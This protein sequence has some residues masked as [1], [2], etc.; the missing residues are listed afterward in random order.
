M[1]R[2]REESFLGLHFD[3]HADTDCT[4]V[5]KTVTDEMI[6][7]IVDKVNPEYIQCDCSGVPGYSSYPT[8]VANPVPGFVKDQLRIW[9]NVTQAADIP[10]LVHF[11]GLWS[12]KNVRNHPEW[13]CV[14]AGG[15]RSDQL[16]SYFSDYAEELFIPQLK[17]LIDE[18]D[19]NGVWVDADS[20]VA[21][22]DFR[23]EALDAYKSL[24]GHDK[25]D[26][27][28]DSA[29]FADFT[30]FCRDKYRSYLRNYVDK[31][32]AYSPGFQVCTNWAYSSYMPE[33]VDIDVDFLSGDVVPLNGFNH[34]RFDSRYLVHQGTPW[35][36]M[37]WSFAHKPGT[38][39][40]VKTAL[41]MMQE[42]AITIAQGGA[43]TF[44]F[45]QTRR[46]G[47]VAKWQM[48]IMAEVAQFCRA[49]QPYCFQ[50]P[51]V[52]QI[53][54][55]HSS[56][57]YY[58]KNERLFA[59]RNPFVI[60]A[61]DMCQPQIGV[62]QCLLEAQNVVDVVSEHQVERC[63]DAYGLVVIP[64]VS[65][66]KEDFRQ[67]LL[68]YV[69]QGGNLL[70]IGTDSVKIFQDELDV[71]LEGPFTDCR[72]LDN[73]GAMTTVNA[74]LKAG[75]SDDSRKIGRL[76]PVRDFSDDCLDAASVR[77]YGKGKIAG[78]YFDIGINYSF[79]QTPTLRKFLKK[80]VDTSFTD[81]LV[82]VSGS[83]FIDVSIAADDNRLCVNLLNTSGP[84]GN[85]HVHVFDELPVLRDIEVKVAVKSRPRNVLLQP[86]G[87][88]LEYEFDG[89]SIAFKL[90]E[91]NVHSVVV[92]ET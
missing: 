83:H 70:L 33:P 62:L 79:F 52:P 4:E 17:E 87:I 18:Y 81:P 48:D 38:H 77:D 46:D 36:I 78:I 53:A 73:E 82:R 3:F 61:E 92:I 28:T 12:Q 34:S 10:L 14:D 47:S 80:I 49:R 86:D 54:M 67:K 89:N 56:T 74:Y 90:E 44:Y 42:A 63:L 25:Q 24:S 75:I 84:H 69:R 30:E 40:D 88:E 72:W 43:V 64:E 32:H 45:S 51:Q 57:H 58:R 39:G 5:G 19:V 1:K 9:R 7:Y 37:V 85:T 16:N 23:A 68:D 76:H 22:Q 13:A 65:T 20:W 15:N 35:D 91:L 50:M 59:P 6:Q 31:L 55:L 8:K 27:L 11:C 41:Q 29:V 21:P 71:E 66:L 2:S 26:I 60:D